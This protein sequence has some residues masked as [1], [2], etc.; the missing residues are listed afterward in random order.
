M[1]VRAYGGQRSPNDIDWWRSGVRNILPTIRIRYALGGG[2]GVYGG[3]FV[4]EGAKAERQDA[5]GAL[6]TQFC[7]WVLGHMSFYGNKGSVEQSSLFKCVTME[8]FVELT[9]ENPEAAS[10][11]V[12]LTVIGGGL[13]AAL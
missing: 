1:P 11:L 13:P 9:N 7:N 3:P 8:C 2:T 4:I 10:A 6:V 5:T 12:G